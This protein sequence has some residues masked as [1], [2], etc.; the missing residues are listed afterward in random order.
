MYGALAE[1]E[2]VTAESLAQLQPD[3]Y[4]VQDQDPVL[5]T[6]TTSLIDADSIP[7]LA[8]RRQ[9]AADEAAR[10]LS[11]N[12]HLLHTS[13]AE[14]VPT[15]VDALGTARQVVEAKHQFGADSPEYKERFTGLVLDSERLLAEAFSHKTSEYFGE[16]IRNFN[17]QDVGY[18][19]H[20]ISLSGMVRNG[21]SPSA[22]PEEQARRVN[23]YVK[24]I[25]TNIGLGQSIANLGL[26]GMVD[27]LPAPAY[28]LESEGPQSLS[29]DVTHVSECTDYAIRDYRSNPKA[30][31]GGYAPAVEKIMISRA[32][33]SD[34]SGDRVEEQVALPGLFITQDIVRG[35]IADHTS[36]IQHTEFTKTELHATQFVGVS[37]GRLV[38]FVRKLDE[39][40][41]E[42][43]DKNIFMG[44]E[45]PADHPKDY[46]VFMEE[47]EV[48]RKK[49]AP[50]PTELAEYLVALEENDTDGLLAE[51]LV[52]KFLKAT[53]LEVAE[54]H[55]E[56]AEA[57][58]DK[59]TAEG[60]EEV[61]RLKAQ[62]R[63]AEALKL[64]AQVEKNA[65]EV[66][67]CG[68]GCGAE[69]VDP[70]SPEAKAA[71]ELGLKG[72]MLHNTDYSCTN[73]HAFGL[74]HDYEGNTVCVACKATK[75]AGQ[76]VKIPKEE[77]E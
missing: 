70:S 33:F 2:A 72:E 73:C 24:E 66:S 45:V 47:A 52:N 16:V 9:R 43:H 14:H 4:V 20:G 61:A 54:N 60:F 1:I 35:V 18:T 55:P 51:T 7:E 62:G 65:P 27:R 74:Y 75:L 48:R 46:E 49:L 71:R 28:T 69:N 50:K 77:R 53:L 40:A 36:D 59:E 63:N 30:S 31:H 8:F 58:F 15:P 25:G 6:N 44:E 34:D 37:S 26:Q 21:L 57:M 56:L 17:V 5:D 38:E 76:G 67:Y 19:S 32:H 29:I 10:I 11:Q 12:R 13:E 68:A 42:E 23:D 41:G 3:L 39:R 22:E 64:Q